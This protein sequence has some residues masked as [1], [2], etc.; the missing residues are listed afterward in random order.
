M[1]VATIEEIRDLKV[2]SYDLVLIQLLF[3][4]FVCMIENVGVHSTQACFQ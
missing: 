4:T 1:L 2:G 3:K